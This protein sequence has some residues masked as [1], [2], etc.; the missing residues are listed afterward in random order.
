[1]RVKVDN[2]EMRVLSTSSTGFPDKEV[3]IVMQHD[4]LLLL[5]LV[6]SPA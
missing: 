4:G 5:S 2:A 6:P 3:G 1:M